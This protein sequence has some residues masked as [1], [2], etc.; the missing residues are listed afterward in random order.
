MALVVEM[1]RR[2]KI[3]IEKRKACCTRTPNKQRI[4]LF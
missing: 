1:I 3:S 4:Y 2:L